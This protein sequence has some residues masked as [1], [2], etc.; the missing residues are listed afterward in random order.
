MIKSNELRLGNL[1]YNTKGEVDVVTVEAIKYI[2]DYEG[3]HQA[4]PIPLTEEWLIRMGFMN[5][6]KN[7]WWVLELDHIEIHVRIPDGKV[8]LCFYGKDYVSTEIKA[9]FVHS[10]QNLIFS[11]TAEELTIQ[12]KTEG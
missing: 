4:T 12:P 11:L 8:D 10:I 1:I 9:E 7:A 3:T 5:Y 2:K 6:N